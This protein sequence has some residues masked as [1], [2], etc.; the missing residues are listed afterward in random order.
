MNLCVRILAAIVLAGMAFGAVSKCGAEQ[1]SIG[2]R[3]NISII[4][5]PVVLEQHEGQFCLTP[6]TRVVAQSE[7]RGEAIKLIDYL[8]P[9]M[10][11]RLNLSEDSSA[12]QDS[13]HLRLESSARDRLGEE[14]YEVKVTSRSALIVAAGPAGLFYGGQTLR[15]LLPPAIFSQRKTHEIE[16]TMPCVRIV[17]YPRFEWRGLLIDPARHFI[18]VQ[19]V[20]TFID[21]M[22]IHK[23]NRLQVHLTDNEGWRIEI[24]KYPKLTELG[25]Q[26]DWNLRRKGGTGPRCFG[27]Y[28]QDD[29]RRIVCYAAQHHI[30]I[31]PEIEMPYHTGAAIVAYPELGINTGDLAELPPAQRW[32]KTKGLIAPR[33]ETAAFLQDVLTEVIEVF[34][35]K[36]IHIGG[37]EANIRLWAGDPEMQAQ[38]QRLKLKDAHELH[39]WL[40]KQMDTF[41]AENGRRLV[42]W[43]EILQGGLAPNAV[44][45]SWRG[46]SGGLA[47]AKAGHDVV[48][49]PTSHTYFDYRQAPN[50]T[51]LGRSV[52]NVEKVYTFEPIPQQLNAQQAK[53]V[54]GGQGQLWGEL[55]ADRQRREFMAFPRACALSE[56]LWSPKDDRSFRQFVP[57]LVQHLNRLKCA[58]VNYR[59]LDRSLIE[60]G[61]RSAEHSHYLINNSNVIGL[62]GYIHGSRITPDNK[63]VL[64]DKTPAQIPTGCHCTPPNAR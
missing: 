17:D 39:S 55:I 61:A 51:G 10:G 25:S 62:K 31:V 58:G 53:H 46:T 52:I 42:G 13:I 41:L 60:S 30:T 29:I 1:R 23:F 7:A 35:S 18:P 40:I 33:P 3:P 16:W 24:K 6:K 9:A 54:L 14:G 8:A 11:Y 20:E 59:P 19:D 5:E 44:V 64:A 37:D 12:P 27:F 15:Q 4:P 22:T 49:A 63:L 57:R 32:G 34:A 21:I 48:M 56:V 50:E 43:D 45:M 26:M 2:P 28:T 38:M 36:D 47:A